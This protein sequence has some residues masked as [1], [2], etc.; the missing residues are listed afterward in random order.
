MVKL[1]RTA[2]Y[3]GDLGLKIYNLDLEVQIHRP[4]VIASVP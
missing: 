4:M 2:S 1:L 3:K